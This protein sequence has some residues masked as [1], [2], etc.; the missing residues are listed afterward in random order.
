MHYEIQAA[1][2]LLERLGTGPSPVSPWT[3]EAEAH[4]REW[5][6]EFGLIRSQAARDR[7]RKT[8]P[9][10]LS[11]RV[12]ATAADPGRLA[13]ATAWIGWLFLIDD[14]LDEGATGKD[15]ALVRDRLRPFADMAE[16][17]A[18]G[19]LPA[20]DRTA[21]RVRLPLLAALI[22]VWGRI[23]PHMPAGW[24]AT[25]AQHYFDYLCGCEWEAAN[26]ARGRIPP[27][28]EFARGRREAG[29]IWPSLDLLEYVADVPVPDSFRGDPLLAGI[30]TACADV[31]CWT[32]D[33][34]TVGKERAHGDVHN[35]VIVLQHATG[36]DERKALEMVAQ[37]IE[38]R[39]ADFEE[40]RRR[41]LALDVGADS[42][43]GALVSHVTGLHHWMRGHLEWGLRTI[44]YNASDAGSAAY[45]EDLLSDT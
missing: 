5:A 13:A 4:V 36:C 35:L 37:R 44:R 45:L 26:R 7:F 16:E 40:L 6:A 30:R 38:A 18:T 15:P 29:A 33:L 9:G 23:S 1:R 34:L 17:M 24:R 20:A 8:A 41:V 12:Y 21:G 10:E 3:P 32:D 28:A 25:F 42:A 2:I 14:Q 31:V 43:K 11:G 19:T 22:E 39:V 27:E